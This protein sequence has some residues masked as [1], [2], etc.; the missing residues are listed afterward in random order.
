ME[1][2]ITVCERVRN[3]RPGNHNVTAIR[4]G[5]EAKDDSRGDWYQL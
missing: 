5:F 2:H 4:A 1:D 3:S